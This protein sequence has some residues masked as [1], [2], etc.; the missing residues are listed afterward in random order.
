MGAPRWPYSSEGGSR[1]LELPRPTFGAPQRRRG[2]PLYRE[3]SRL[4]GGGAHD[5]RGVMEHPLPTL[6]LA[7]EQGGC[8]Y[9]GD[10]DAPAHLGEDVL[11][12]RDPG[13]AAGDGDLDVAD[14]EAD[15]PGVRED[16]LP[17]RTHVVPAG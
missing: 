13:Q 5:V 6:G 9:R 8:D 17:R 15:L 14:G 4:G 2:A 11:G 12:A 10:G 16:R 3:A 1:P 7:L